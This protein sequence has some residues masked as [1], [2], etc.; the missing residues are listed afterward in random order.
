MTAHAAAAPYAAR[1]EIDYPERLDRLSTVFRLI[2]IVPI[3]IVLSLLTASGNQTMVTASG[4]QVAGTGG[5]LLAGLAGAT[6]LMIIV[7]LRYPRWWFDFARELTRFGARVSAYLA[8][9]TDR[10]PSTVDEQ[11]VHLEIEYPDVERD[12]NRWLPL[13]KWLLAIP[14]YFVLAIPVDRRPHRDRH[15]LVRDPG[16]G[17]LSETAVRLRG[18][19]QPVDIAGHRLRLP[20]RYRSVSAVQPQRRSLAM[21][22]FPTNSWRKLALAGGVLYLMTFAFSIP[23][24]FLLEPVLSNPDYIVSGG[25][26]SQVLLGTLFDLITA[27]ACIGTAVALFPVIRRQ[28]ETASL[29]F[30]TTRIFEGAIIVIGVASLMAVVAMRQAGGATGTDS[31]GLVAVGQALVA[32]RDQTFLLGPGVMP[33]LNALLLGYVLYRSRL[34]P[35]LIPAVGLIGAP[36]FLA[37]AT[38]T[39]LGV[40]EQVS[41]LSGIAVVPIFFWELSLGL[42][43]TFKGFSLN[44]PLIAAA[45]AG[46]SEGASAVA[47]SGTAVATKAGVA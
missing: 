16:H 9:L 32:V 22:N 3:A 27:L 44:S 38:A 24:V 34:V 7:R 18:R 37:S 29:G 17:P 28:S 10:Y 46:S 11:S 21:T 42:W 4:Q 47:P 8:L 13:V 2:W 12:L 39:L 36:I 31:S 33:G 15:R 23:A 40:N 41:L 6:A 30:V 1:L 19:R 43:L 20:A 5:G 35:R 25:A 26:D 14:H 45:E